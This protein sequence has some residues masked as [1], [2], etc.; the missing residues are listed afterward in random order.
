MKLPTEVTDCNVSLQLADPAW[1]AVPVAVCV[2]VATALLAPFQMDQAVILGITG[3]CIIL[4]IGNPVPPWFTGLVGI[5]LVGLTSSTELAFSGF[6]K[7]VLWLIVFGLVVGEGINRGDLATVI[8]RRIG[9][10]VATDTPGGMRDG[11]EAGVD[12]VR[13]FRRL[14]IVLCLGGLVFALMV[15]SSLVRVL[16]MAP[17]LIKTGQIFESKTARLGILFG[18]LFATFYGG[19]GILTGFLPNVVIAGVLESTA[20]I[21]ITW[22]RWLVTM[23]PVMGLGRILLIMGVIYLLYRPA[24]DSKVTVESPAVG[25]D[26][27]EVRRT[28]AFLL[29]G[30][31]LWSTD[32]LHGLH[33]VFGALVVA[34]LF[35]APGIGTI[36]FDVIRD[37]D[38]SII[39]FVGAVFAISAALSETGVSDVAARSLLA[40]VPTNAPLSITLLAVFG[41]TLVLVFLV[42]GVATASILTTVLVS[43]AA[44]AGLPLVPV[45]QVEAMAL[46]SI[47]FPYQSVVLVVILDYDLVEPLE[48]VKITTIL[49][50]GTIS[51]LLPLQLLVFWLF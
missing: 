50:L 23:F 47:F 43:F 51:L 32:F 46:G 25:T 9:Q 20:G 1:L 6:A 38:F 29:V 21:S 28:V 30:V 10:W 17:I 22:S 5:G 8:E 48:L 16:V 39:F 37:I 36:S 7:P 42:E 44:E 2:G 49:S 31:A 24:P 15:P 33:P 13:V 41:V 4:W 18:P 27:A 12:T 45:V 26:P 40:F 35:L 19:V 11:V 34:A 3:F 14:L